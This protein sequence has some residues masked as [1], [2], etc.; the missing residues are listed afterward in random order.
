MISV[1]SGIS[2]IS[3]ISSIIVISDIIVISSISGIIVIS[4]IIVISG[5]SIINY[6][7]YPTSYDNKIQNKIIIKYNKIM[8]IHSITFPSP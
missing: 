2:V 1:T 3:V 8:T 4:D 7:K 5:I 6:S